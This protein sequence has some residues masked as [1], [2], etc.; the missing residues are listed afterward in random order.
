MNIYTEKGLTRF[1]NL[2]AGC[3]ALFSVVMAAL[4]LC[5]TFGG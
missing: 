4:V 3:F 2:C 1:I 5:E